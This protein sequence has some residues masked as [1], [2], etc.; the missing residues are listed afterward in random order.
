MLY[1]FM[2]SIDILL[3]M[4]VHDGSQ[5]FDDGSLWLICDVV[6]FV[7]HIS[8]GCGDPTEE[9][10][11]V[12]LGGK[13]ML[14]NRTSHWDSGDIKRNISSH[15]CV[16]WQNSEESHRSTT[17][18]RA[19]TVFE[20]LLRKHPTA[21]WLPFFWRKPGPQCV[22]RRDGQ[23]QLREVRSIQPWWKPWDIVGKSWI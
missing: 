1:D 9:W 19:P 7:S 2:L 8:L 15:G 5:W 18:Q 16:A 4:V 3:F 23:S 22:D 13:R 6:L 11:W 12:E 20:E 17:W 14:K 21:Q 10:T